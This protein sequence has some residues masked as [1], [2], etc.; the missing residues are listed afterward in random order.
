MPAPPAADDVRAQLARILA[1]PGFA[2]SARLSRFLTFVVE[3]TLAGEAPH[4]KEYLLGTEVFDRP[5]DYDPRLDSIVRVEARRL[6][7]KLAEY[8]D[9]PGAGDPIV[10]RIDKGSYVP[11]FDAAAPPPPPTMT[12]AESATPPGEPAVRSGVPAPPAVPAAAVPVPAWR[13]H[14]WSSTIV[15]LG[16]AVIGLL[17]WREIERTREAGRVHASS[18][19]GVAVLPLVRYEP[20][21]ETRSDALADA[22]TDGVIAELARR[23]GVEVASR[24]SVMQYRDLRASLSAIANDLGVQAVVEGRVQLTGTRLWVEVR[25]VDARRDRKVWVEDFAGEAGA[26][27]ELERRIAAALGEVIVA[28]FAA[29]VE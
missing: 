24:T 3:R 8:Y 29:T 19:I 21:A 13:R 18:S 22:L 2:N 7:G 4:V 6:R 5:G 26:Q 1:S 17:L 10:I 16:A 28:R 23:P 9:G 14:A 11:A 15:A 20:W 27:R 12:D 25:L